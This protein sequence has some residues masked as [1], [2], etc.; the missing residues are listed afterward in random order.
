M[1]KTQPPAAEKATLGGGCF[2]C[3]E[4]MFKAI[5]GVLSVTSGYAGGTKETP[6]YQE[7]CTGTTG[8]AEV[9]QVVFDPNKVSAAEHAIKNPQTMDRR[10]RGINQ[11]NRIKSADNR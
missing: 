7:V 3:G 10:E 8:H 9:I 11:I 5:P 1:G 4:A 6:T 2:W